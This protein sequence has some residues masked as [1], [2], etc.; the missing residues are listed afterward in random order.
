MTEAFISY[1]R[2]DKEFV[3]KLYEAFVNIDRPVWVDWDSIPLTADWRQEIYQGIEAANNFV[4]VLSPDSV[5]S[6]VCGEEVEHAIQNNKR[7]VPIVYREID[8]S[9]VHPELAKINWIF[10][11]NGADFD[12]SF[13]QL[14][15]SIDTDLDHVKRHT[16]LQ[17]RAIEWDKKNRDASF[18]LR[19]NDLKEAEE[20]IALSTKKQPQPTALQTQYIVAS[21]QN[22]IKRQ[23]ATLGGAIAGLVVM[24]GLTVFAENQRRYA[25][26]QRHEARKEETIALNALSEAHLANHDGLS[27]MLASVKAAQQS[28]RLNFLSDDIKQETQSRLRE[29]LYNVQERNR[30]EQ[31]EDNVNSVTLS[32]DGEWLAS[33]SDDQTVRLW[34]SNGELVHTL[35]HEN[36]VRTVVFSPDDR[37]VLS[38]SGDGTMKLWNLDGENVQTIEPSSVPR[39]AI[40]SPDGEAIVSG[41]ADGTMTVWNR[42]GELQQTIEAHE[43]EI[44]WVGFSSDGQSIVTASSDRTA[45]VWTREG[46]LELTLEGHTDKVW[47]AHFSPDSNE[48]ATVSSDNTMKLWDLDGDPPV[49]FEAHTNWVSSLSFSPDGDR[50]ATGSDDDTVKLWS[51]DGT[52]LKTFLGHSGGVKSVRIAPDGKTI[53]SASA[54]RTIRLRSLEG[55]L[56]EILQGHTSAVKSVRFAPEGKLVASVGTDNQVKLWDDEG[57]LIQRVEYNAGLRDV[58][59]SPDGET[60]YTASY[61]NTLQ[62]WDVEEAQRYGSET[63]PLRIFAGHTSTV[64]NLNVS[65]DGRLLVSA[66]GDGT[67]RLWNPDGSPVANWEAHEPEVTDVAFVSNDRLASVGGDNLVKIWDFEGNLLQTLEGHENWINALSVRPDGQML[68]TASG[69]RTIILWQRNESGEFDPTPY[70]VLEGH[71]DW[72]WD[73]SFS[74]DGQ[75]LASAGKD[76][77]VKLWN[78]NGELLTTLREHKNWVRAVEFSPNGKEFA[79]ASADKTIILWDVKSI[80]ALDGQQTEEDLVQLL[81]RSCTWLHDYLKTNSKLTDSDRR[82]CP[83]V[84]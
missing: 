67:I 44:N 73:I 79:S 59:F 51:R 36:S 58:A 84:V 24:A 23:R 13:E 83:E 65:A 27:A 39:A 72:V 6:Q 42:D 45:K 77:T 34:R 40:F 74:P 68:A 70:K 38:A 5:S 63:Q 55:T 8:Y 66:G 50:I 56:I 28:Q 54:D 7:L 76:D 25:V 29:A 62:S 15:N 18:V 41:H 2:R 16:R 11:N 30:L 35:E 12:H 43:K 14:I 48:I 22:K 26:E 64:K 21:G 3:K 4:F 75:L 81:D 61:D 60:M 32:S 80:E 20:W 33:A 10:F 17:Q 46:E 57:Q 47:E 19:G 9:Q 37:F 49:T 31:H 69:D 78:A 52:L 53:A 82:A 71:E 1:S